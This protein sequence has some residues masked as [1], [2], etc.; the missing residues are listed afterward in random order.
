MR[1]DSISDACS[2]NEMAINAMDKE[3]QKVKRE[4][5]DNTKNSKRRIETQAIMK[6]QKRQT[7]ARRL[8]K[9]VFFEID[10]FR[11]RSG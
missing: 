5:I 6:A 1:E 11:K 3:T 7:R 8:K 10:E 4:E 2:V 9:V